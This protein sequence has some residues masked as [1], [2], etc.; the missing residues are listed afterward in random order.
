MLNIS[1]EK[2]YH[3]HIPA[4]VATYLALFISLAPYIDF[5]NCS[6]GYTLRSP[7]QQTGEG[8]QRG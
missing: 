3:G 7:H 8:N 6:L 5:S 4:C 2:R 1:H